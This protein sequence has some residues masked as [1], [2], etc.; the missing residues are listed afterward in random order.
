MKQNFK[1]VIGVSCLLILSCNSYESSNHSV[2]VESDS[3]TFISDLG[4][5][6][7]VISNNS[8]SRY[9]L[10]SEH[11]EKFK[12]L[13]ASDT[14]NSHCYPPKELSQSFISNLQRIQDIHVFNPS[15]EHKIEVVLVG[16]R[17]EFEH[18]KKT[19]AWILIMDF[20]F[21]G[22]KETTSKFV[23]RFRR[24]FSRNTKDFVQINDE[25]GKVIKLSA[26]L[27]NQIPENSLVDYPFLSAF[28]YSKDVQDGLILILQPMTVPLLT[29]PKSGYYTVKLLEKGFET[30]NFN[31]RKSSDA[32]V[33]VVKQND[34]PIELE[35]AIL[36]S[37]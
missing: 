32:P 11:Q 19:N 10:F 21:I 7:T 31:H 33:L 25:H 18:R 24:L 28:H 9:Q 17:T 15:L 30:V 37:E 4:E 36:T 22:P 6:S 8:K 12:L 5:S 3:Q 27:N 13:L 16:L 23:D 35:Y 29:K 14:E 34:E 20:V 2:V 1:Y 26:L